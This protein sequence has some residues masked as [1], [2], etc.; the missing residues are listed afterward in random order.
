MGTIPQVIRPIR[1]PQPDQGNA[2]RVTP[3][4]YIQW[5]FGA[6]KADLSHWVRYFSPANT[7]AYPAISSR[8]ATRYLLRWPGIRVWQGQRH[9]VCGMGDRRP[10]YST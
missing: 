4:G 5:L 10:G 1:I 9:A 6:S 8:P 7:Q 2:E 3:T